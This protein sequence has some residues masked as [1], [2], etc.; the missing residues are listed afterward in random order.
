M[1]N[2]AQYDKLVAEIEKSKELAWQDVLATENGRQ[3]IFEIIE[4]SGMYVVPQDNVVFHNGKRQLG[5]QIIQRVLTIKDNC[6]I[7][8]QDEDLKRA[9]TIKHRLEGLEKESKSYNILDNY[10]ED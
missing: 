2:E 10:L 5:S 9:R 3:V 8:M 4:M 6:Y 7:M 1:T